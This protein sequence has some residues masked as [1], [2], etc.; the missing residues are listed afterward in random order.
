[1]Q[2]RKLPIAMMAMAVMMAGSAQA[3]L[4]GDTVTVTVNWL[5]GP[6]ADSVL[7]AH[8][9][10]EFTNANG[11]NI[12][13]AFLFPGESIDLQSLAIVLTFTGSFQGTIGVTGI[14]GVVSGLAAQAG[15]FGTLDQFSITDSGHSIS[16]RYIG[17]NPTAPTG[18]S[19][20]NLTFDTN[21]NGGG[22]DPTP[23][24][25]TLALMGAGLAGLAWMK[26]R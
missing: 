3:S 14:D 4:I 9:A 5:S 10:V 17:G 23:E 24:P 13:N 6:T 18:V 19:T 15:S 8:P 11:T 2:F 21:T 26:R 7:V 25:A 1:M 16:F 22:G 20:L 12:G